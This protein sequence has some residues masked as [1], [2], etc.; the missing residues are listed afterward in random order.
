M[1][2]RTPLQK[3]MKS[4]K[5]LKVFEKIILYHKLKRLLLVKLFKLNVH[6]ITQCVLN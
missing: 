2:F 5:H 6:P 1:I 4:F 3:Q